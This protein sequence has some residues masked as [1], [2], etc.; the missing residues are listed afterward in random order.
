MQGD[1][2]E[3]NGRS[4]PTITCSREF[5]RAVMEEDLACID[6]MSRKYGTDFFLRIPAGTGVW[7]GPNIHPIHFAASNRRV[8]S[9]QRL[10]ALGA[11]PGI[12]NQHGQTA[13]HLVIS[14]WPSFEISG[15]KPDSKF[16]GAV[17]NMCRRAEVCLRLLCDVP[18][19]VNTQVEDKRQQTALHLSVQCQSL[20][21]VQ[22]L[23][24]YGADV[25]LTDSSGMT[26]LHMSAGILHKDI[27]DCLVEQGADINMGVK[28]SGNTPL[29]LA[30]VAIALKSQK[31]L[32]DHMTFISDLLEKGTRPDVLNNAGRTPLHEACSF[33]N[34]LLVDL[35]LK[36]GADVNKLTSS[37]E[38]C[39]F[40]FL[41][42]PPN[43]R[44]RALMVK[45]LSLTSPLTVHDIKGQLPSTLM[46]PCFAQQR[47]QML[48]LTQQPRKLLDLC[49]NLLYLN[50]IQSGK[51]HLKA[52]LPETMYN[53]VFNC[54]EERVDI[55]FETDANLFDTTNSN[56]Q[57]QTVRTSSPTS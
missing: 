6:D 14:A 3:S 7:K 55:S 42:Y 45:L 54:L 27:T 17:T 19:N 56:P 35:L 9:L 52:I 22:I 37:G 20:P 4:D 30:L 48:K 53:S 47:E 21:A 28:S 29:H 39:L 57:G 13:L 24:S 2:E 32:E 49:K 50:Y 1:T 16:H 18:V 40:L 44:N 51:E 46:L 43:V 10:L 26:P 36:H 25:N 41:N 8:K 23:C 33:G 38:N 11:D 34:K 5:Y 12:R 15:S 31:N